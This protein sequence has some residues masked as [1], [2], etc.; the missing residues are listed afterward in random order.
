MDKKHQHTVAQKY[1]TKNTYRTQNSFCF[2]QNHIIS[3]P[4]AVFLSSQFS[5]VA[6]SCL[7]LCDPMDHSTPGLPVHHQFL[8]FT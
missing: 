2:T 3:I 1:L 8:E 6:Q 4:K 7:M 5:S